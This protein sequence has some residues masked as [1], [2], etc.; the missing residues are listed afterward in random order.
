MNWMIILGNIIAAIAV[1][2]LGIYH[3]M[4]VAAGE[5][6]SFFIVVAAIAFAMAVAFG[7]IAIFHLVN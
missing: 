2:L 1:L 7:G 6:S 4:N 3:S 5:S